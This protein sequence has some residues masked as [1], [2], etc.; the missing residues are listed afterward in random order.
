MTRFMAGMLGGSVNRFGIQDLKDALTY[1]AKM[2]AVDPQRL[3]AIGF[4]MGG[5]FAIAWACTDSRLKAIAPFYGA[6]PRPLDEAV[7]R[8]C[9]VVGSYPERDFTANAGRKLDAAL[10]RAGVPHDIKIYEDA[11]HSFFNDD[12]RAYDAVASA[13]AWS[14]VLEFFADRLGAARVPA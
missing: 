1:L 5:S 2:P 14:R 8:S 13:D 7:R 3:G 11:R 4:C 10:T 6:N 9:P 12:G